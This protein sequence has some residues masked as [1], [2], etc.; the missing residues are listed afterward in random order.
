[1]NSIGHQC[2]ACVDSQVGGYLLDELSPLTAAR[3]AELGAH[4]GSR[5]SQAL[6]RRV[7]KDLKSLQRRVERVRG[8]RRTH[9]R[10]S[11]GPP[12]TLSASGSSRALLATGACTHACR[13]AYTRTRAR[14][15]QH[16]R[17]R[18]LWCLPARA[19][20]CT[21]T[22]TRMCVHT[23]AFAAVCAQCGGRAALCY[24]VGCKEGTMST[25][26]PFADCV[27]ARGN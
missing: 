11:S 17:A 21:N 8:Q 12:K 10:R 14:A 6:S 24:S 13:Q 5:G 9:S 2:N 15:H 1:M 3:P 22:Q 26:G 27:R 23:P 19:H 18:A 16:E 4:V 20:R 7:V 25:T